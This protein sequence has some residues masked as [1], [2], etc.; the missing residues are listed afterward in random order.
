MS[1]VFDGI[2]AFSYK[3]AT[4]VMTEYQDQKKRLTTNL[5]LIEGHKASNPE[6]W[7]DESERMSQKILTDGYAQLEKINN[8]IAVLNKVL[9]VAEKLFKNNENHNANE[10]ADKYINPEL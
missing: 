3:V 1:G 4:L 9:E 10:L 8:N 2:I 6:E 7:T 5:G